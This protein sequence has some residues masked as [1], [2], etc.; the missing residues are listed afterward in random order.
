[1]PQTSA[2]WGE[3]FG[4]STTYHAVKSPNK[5]PDIGCLGT[6]QGGES[7]PWRRWRWWPGRPLFCSPGYIL[8]AGYEEAKILSRRQPIDAVIA[9][10]ATDA[11]TRAKLELV[12]SVRTYAERELGLDVRQLHHLLPARPR[13]PPPGGHRRAEGLLHA[14]H[15]VVPH[16]GRVP[17]QGVL[18]TPTPPSPR[19]PASRPRATTPPSA[20]PAPSAPWA[21]STTR[22]S[23]PSS[24]YDD[25]ALASTVIHE[26]T[27]NT[28]FIKAR[29]PST[30]ASPT[31]W[32]TWGHRVLLRAWRA[33]RRPLPPGPRPLADD[34]RFGR[35]PA[36][37]RGAGG[38][39]PRPGS[40]RAPRSWPAARTVFARW[41]RR[42]R[43][44]RRPP[45]QRPPHLPRAP[46]QQ[47]LPHGT[48]SLLPAPRPLRRTCTA[49]S[50]CPFPGA[51]ARMIEAAE[52]SPETPPSKPSSGWPRLDPPLY[53]MIPPAPEGLAPGFAPGRVASRVSCFA[54]GRFGARKFGARKVAPR[55]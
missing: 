3:L 41:K 27:H 39:L 44:R 32:A 30:R 28:T 12:R 47:R 8:R 54:P 37:H 10:P 50:T 33:R 36:P 40:R 5:S 17:V 22:S 2:P 43:P 23:A 16:R 4:E 53:F 25:V 11:A 46:H 49:P 18:P 35:A 42:L 15:V 48:P 6:L 51:V 21:G 14:V 20:R 45:L 1:M 7:S 38:G 31:S 52:S 34:L 13:H 24:A 9:A 29:S 26:L 19:P 55:S